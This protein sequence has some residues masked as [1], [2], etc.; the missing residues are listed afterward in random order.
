MDSKYKIYI[1]RARNEINL[2]KMIMQISEDDK[3]QKEIFEMP[4]DTYYSS[5][6]S[7]AY[8]SIFYMAKAYLITKDIATQ[9]PE[10]HRK[11]YE[12]FKK[13]VEKGVVDIQLLNIYQQLITRADTLLKIFQI[14]KI[15]R[16]KFT[17]KTLPQA[18]IGPARSSVRNAEIF[19]KHINSLCI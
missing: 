18:N 16:G 10:E 12:E 1:K 2:S 11:T 19:F 14:E 9:P 7:H 8:Y 4:K 13:L 15:K 6:I 5:V 3:I 17:Y